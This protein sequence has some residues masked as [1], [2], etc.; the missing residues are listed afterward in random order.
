MN[1][2]FTAHCDAC[3]KN[4]WHKIEQPCTMT[5]PKRDTCETC[6]HT[7]VDYEKMEPCKGTLRLIDTSDLAPQFTPYLHDYSKRLI[8]KMNYGETVRGYVGKT[9][10]WKPCYMLMS[11]INSTGSSE[12]LHHDDVI[13]QV[14]T[15]KR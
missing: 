2:D 11:K 9:T 7:E 15:M 6:H 13:V 8:V 3:G 4:T 12:L 14:L 1:N 10:G 5:Y